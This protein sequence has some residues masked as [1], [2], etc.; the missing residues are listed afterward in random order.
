MT[1]CPSRK[2]LHIMNRK[3]TRVGYDLHYLTK[4]S[5]SLLLDSW[6]RPAVGGPLKQNPR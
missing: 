5:Y 2:I 6:R 4:A 1:D 3:L